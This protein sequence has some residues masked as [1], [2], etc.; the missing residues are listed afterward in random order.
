[1]H[2]ERWK[3][4]RRLAQ[5]HLNL[6]AMVCLVIENV[7]QDQ[8]GG[9]VAKLAGIVY[10]TDFSL[11]E[12]LIERVHEFLDTRIFT[13][14]GCA[15]T[16]E[17]TVEFGM[18]RRC[19]LD[20]GLGKP[21]HPQPVAEQDVIERQVN[22]PESAGPFAPVICIGELRTRRVQALVRAGIVPGHGLKVVRQGSGLHGF[23]LQH[24]APVPR[25][26]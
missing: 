24:S 12:T 23:R 14:S 3:A 1:M 25:L 21:G 11:Q 5:H 15:K 4:Y 20:F 22:A 2:I 26:H 16:A 13:L 17:I 8:G 7:R 10:V 9:I 6:P 18:K 19:G